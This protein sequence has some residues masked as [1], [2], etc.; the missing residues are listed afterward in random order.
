M[1]PIKLALLAIVTVVALLLGILGLAYAADYTV[2]ATVT[3]KRCFGAFSGTPNSVTVQTKILAI[4][5]TLTDLPDHQCALVNEGNYVQY[6]LRSSR[7]SIYEYEGG[8]CIYDSVGGVG[9]CGA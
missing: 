5:Y 7:T 1:R 6:R 2:E 3:D 8:S 4:E 9:G